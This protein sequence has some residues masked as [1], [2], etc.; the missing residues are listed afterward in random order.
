MN[1]HKKK[2]QD[3]E[4][5]KK[6]ARVALK[7]VAFTREIDGPTLFSDELDQEKPGWK[8]L[9]DSLFLPQREET[10]NKI[11]SAYKK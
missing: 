8:F 9:H 2:F 3:K 1:S 11:V 6:M 4:R 10:Y 5:N 7:T